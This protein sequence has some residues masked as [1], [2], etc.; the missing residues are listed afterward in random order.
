M[1]AGA[2]ERENV[3]STDK[4]LKV[5]SASIDDMTTTMVEMDTRLT[6]AEK[7]EAKI[8]NLDQ[9]VD[10]KVDA[11]VQ[12]IPAP[13]PVSE[14]TVSKAVE[15]Y[16]KSNP[17]EVPEA[18]ATELSPFRW[19]EAGKRYFFPVTYWWADQQTA[20]SKW[21]T[22]FANLDVIG[23][24]IINP[25]SGFGDKTEPDFVDLVA[26]LKNSGKPAVGY[27]RTVKATRS[28]DE[29]LAEIKKYQDSYSLDGVFLDEMVNGWSEEESS[30]IPFYTDLYAEIKKLYGSGFLVI[31]N[32]GTNTKPELLGAADMLMSFEKSVDKYL[33]DTDAPVTTAE[34]RKHSPL[35][36]INVAHNAASAEQ[37]TQML[38][39][40]ASENVAFIYVTDDVFSGVEGSESPAN[41]PWD[42]LP[43]KDILDRTLAWCRRQ[44]PATPAAPT[45]VMAVS[46]PGAAYVLDSRFGE[47]TGGDITANLQAAVND[48]AVKVIR[49]PSGEYK[50]GSVNVDKL[51][52]KVLEGQ[53]RDVTK[54]IYDKAASNVPFLATSGGKLARAT[55]SGFTLD[56]GWEKG[57]P[58]RHGG[59]F[60]NA[61]HLTFQGLRV[62]NVGGAGIIL[63]SLGTKADADA[64]GSSFDDIEMENIGLADGTTGFGIR[65]VNNAGNAHLRG[66]KFQGIKGGM[67]VGGVNDKG[68]D[69][70]PSIITIESSFIRMAE[71]NTGFEPI[72]FTK[73]CSEIIVRGNHLWSM[74]N[75]TSLSGSRCKFEGNIVYSAWNFGVALGADDADYP[76][77]V[78]ASVTDNLFMDVGLQN[79]LKPGAKPE[80][81]ALVRL[82]K[83]RRC[84]VKGNSYIGRPGLA[85]FFVK[86]VGQN[87]GHN[88]IA[89][90]AVAKSDFKKTPVVGAVSTDEVQEFKDPEVAA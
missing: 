30:K 38:N 69:K 12:K 48:P 42:S 83:P 44:A 34:Y 65:L 54:L 36:F 15:T 31:G 60:S 78:G 5:L 21:E 22:I 51:R 20:G 67:G 25:R 17:V 64:T 75:G 68:V 27:V 33:A 59:Q 76:E 55:F 79:E 45:P 85:D 11:A 90:N 72:G 23:P 73:G 50:I 88:R 87:G 82:A 61:P 3:L 16:L 49:I 9:I 19:F 57:D 1:G 39:K 7:A 53:G 84:V 8:P 74:D 81:Y 10:D 14:E 86:I 37:A 52:E 77:T 71:S 24:V 18:P 32:P 46:D 35:R 89:D 58:V 63:Q 13:T 28:K 29:I 6:K 41:N 2:I 66:L 40:A 4:Q 70:G 56:L 62:V 47:V 43:N 80:E 26:K